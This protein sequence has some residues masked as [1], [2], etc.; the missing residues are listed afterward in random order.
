MLD[1]CSLSAYFCIRKVVR[2]CFLSTAN[3]VTNISPEQKRSGDR[4]LGSA[5]SEENWKAYLKQHS[6]P[7]AS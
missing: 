1:T 4:R 6:Y 3:E 2:G 7:L 5:L